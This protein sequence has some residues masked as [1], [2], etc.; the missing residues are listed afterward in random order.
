MVEGIPDSGADTYIRMPLSSTHSSFSLCGAFALQIT[1]VFL[2]LKKNSFNFSVANRNPFSFFFNFDLFRV[3]STYLDQYCTV[4]S[5]F[6]DSYQGL[7]PHWPH[8]VPIFCQEQIYS[9]EHNAVL[10][11]IKSFCVHCVNS[12]WG[13]QNVASRTL[14]WWSRSLGLL[15]MALDP[16]ISLGLNLYLSM[17][18]FLTQS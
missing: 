3:T 18:D 15:W 6:T 8:R 9:M 13:C 2:L 14:D 1:H 11:I 10:Q 5:L 4:C 17:E 12:I 16:Y 7:S